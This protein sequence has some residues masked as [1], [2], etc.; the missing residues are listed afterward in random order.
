MMEKWEGNISSGGGEVY[1]S[2]EVG[3]GIFLD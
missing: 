1:K 3:M 2:E